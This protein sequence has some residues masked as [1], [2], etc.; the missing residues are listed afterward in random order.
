MLSCLGA[1]HYRVVI[2]SGFGGSCVVPP[3]ACQ[4]CGLWPVWVELS[5][6]DSVPT[7]QAALGNENL[8][9]SECT[10]ALATVGTREE[11]VL[12]TGPGEI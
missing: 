12:G 11:T 6:E 7:L 4:Y 9:S 2:F 5:G 10:P 1:L 8:Q 3:W